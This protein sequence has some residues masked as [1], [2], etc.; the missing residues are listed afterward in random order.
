MNTIDFN[1]LSISSEVLE[2]NIE[3]TTINYY[4]QYKTPQFTK[5]FKMLAFSRHSVSIQN[6]IVSLKSDSLYTMRGLTDFGSDIRL[7]CESIDDDNIERLYNEFLV[8]NLKLLR[9]LKLGNVAAMQQ[10]SEILALFETS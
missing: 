10:F 3:Y 7:L 4:V 8:L 9:K 2:M 1:E 6:Q 5:H